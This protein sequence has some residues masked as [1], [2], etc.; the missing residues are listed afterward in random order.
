MMSEKSSTIS[1]CQ[2][3]VEIS[4]HKSAPFLCNA[5]FGKNL[6][7]NIPFRYMIQIGPLTRSSENGN[8]PAI[9]SKSPREK[10]LLIEPSYTS[11]L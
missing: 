4:L 1:F 3:I 5:F 8:D 6:V 11:I 2:E 7:F 9:S 10:L